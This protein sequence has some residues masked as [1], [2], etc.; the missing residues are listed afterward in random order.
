MRRSKEERREAR[1]RFLSRMVDEFKKVAF[2]AIFFVLVG[3]IVWYFILA[4]KGTVLNYLLPLG[5]AGSLVSIF[6]VYAAASTSEKKS[7]NKNGLGKK[8]DGVIAKIVDTAEDLTGA[9]G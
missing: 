8:K 9:K 1:S 5:F 7:L 2:I 6:G 4:D 3:G